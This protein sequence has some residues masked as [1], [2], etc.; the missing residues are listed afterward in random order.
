MELIFKP[1]IYFYSFLSFLN[2]KVL[3]RGI[4]KEDLVLDVGSGDKPHWRADVIVDKFPQDNQ[5]RASGEILYDRRKIFV[6]ADV[7]NLPF[8]DKSFDFV[9]CSHLLEHV[10]NPGKA[11]EE[12]TR[13]GKRGYL[14]VPF[15]ILDLLKPFKSHLW[16]CDL[17]KNK[18]VFFRRERVKNF[19]TRVLGK[20]GERYFTSPILQYLFIKNFRFTFISF[21]WHNK[22]NYQVVDKFKKPYFYSSRKIPPK[23]SNLN[24][25][26]YK[27]FYSI[28]TFLFYRKKHINLSL[29]LKNQNRS[30]RS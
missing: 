6:N 4:K 7:Q 16:L 5:Q 28:I 15:A 13:V 20:F 14:E 17:E 11:I 22:I 8:K 26:L 27:I 12:I 24:F 30:C 1:L 21:Y 29:L 18:L 3:I 10:E 25:S 23:K 2:R 19:Y 9:F